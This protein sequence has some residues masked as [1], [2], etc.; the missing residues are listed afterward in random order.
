M[1]IYLLIGMAIPLLIALLFRSMDA[2]ISYSFYMGLAF[3]LI[4]GLING[5]AAGSGDSIRAHYHATPNTDRTE[6]SKW[7]G[8]F[9]Y[10]GLPGMVIGIIYLVKG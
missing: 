3:W 7:A 4:S 10:L 6:R 5:S 9:F 8:K 1:K 2:L